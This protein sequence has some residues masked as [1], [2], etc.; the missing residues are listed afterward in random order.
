MCLPSQE[1]GDK[2]RDRRTHW[3]SRTIT[4][5]RLVASAIGDTRSRASLRGTTLPGSL[6][7]KTTLSGPLGRQTSSMPKRQPAEICE[8]DSYRRTSPQKTY[9]QDRSRVGTSA[10]LG[11]IFGGLSRSAFPATRPGNSC[12]I[13]AS[14]NTMEISKL[15]PSSRHLC[16]ISVDRVTCT[17][18]VSWI[19]WVRRARSDMMILLRLS[20]GIA[21]WRSRLVSR[22]SATSCSGCKHRTAP[23]YD[24]TS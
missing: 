2:F 17:C 18:R 22:W 20:A 4:R 5:P 7:C 16:L 12:S 9:R 14:L 3:T 23:I 10:A 19:M 13:H 24:R 11:G 6:S 21:S 8:P 15:T 1:H